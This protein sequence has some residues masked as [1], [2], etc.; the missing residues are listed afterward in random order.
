MWQGKCDVT[1]GLLL[2]V[3]APV[4]QYILHLD[5]SVNHRIVVSEL[6]GDENKIFVN[7]TFED[8]QGYEQETVH[9]LQVWQT[10]GLFWFS[11][12]SHFCAVWRR[13]SLRGQSN[14]Q[15]Y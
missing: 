15:L 3:D 7:T 13:R 4:K 2:H 12:E 5:K 1:K 10:C 14:L 8:D 9:W 6:Q 11:T